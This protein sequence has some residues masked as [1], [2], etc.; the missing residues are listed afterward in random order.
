MDI[1]LSDLLTDFSDTETSQLSEVLTDNLSIVGNSISVD[2]GTITYDSS[3]TVGLQLDFYNSS[4][5]SIIDTGTV[6]FPM[7]LQMEPIK[8]P[9]P[10]LTV[11]DVNA[12]PSGYIEFSDS[13]ENTIIKF[14]SDA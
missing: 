4:G 14:T 9:L 11:D 10:T 12:A 1:I 2:K 3:N 6:T 8:F 13:V 7:L 5:E